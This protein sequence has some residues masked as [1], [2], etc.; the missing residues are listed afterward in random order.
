[1][2]DHIPPFIQLQRAAAQVI[3][4]TESPLRGR[5]GLAMR[6]PVQ[7]PDVHAAHT[8]CGDVQHFACGRVGADFQP[9]QIANLRHILDSFGVM[10]ADLA[11]ALPARAVHIHFVVIRAV[12]THYLSDALQLVARI[13]VHCLCAFKAKQ[14]AIGIEAVV[15]FRRVVRVGLIQA[16][17]AKS[18]YVHQAFWQLTVLQTQQIARLVIAEH[19]GVIAQP[20]GVTAT[21]QHQPWQARL[22]ASQHTFAASGLDKLAQCVVDIMIDRIH[23]FTIEPVCRLRRIFDAHDVA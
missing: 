1:M 6:Y 13:P 11:L 20:A 16:A 17:V 5:Y 8:Q 3:A 7:V 2:T 22:E 4:H 14:I 9:R 18:V 12:F 10:N 23:L 15:D 19:L 21:G